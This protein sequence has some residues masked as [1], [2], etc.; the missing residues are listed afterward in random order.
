M[1]IELDIS[2]AHNDFPRDIAM[3]KLIAAAIADPLLIPLAVAA[4]SIL[5]EN[6]IFLRSAEQPSRF[7]HICNSQKVGGQGNALTSLIYVM[8]ENDTLKQVQAQYPGATLKAIHGDIAIFGPSVTIF[9]LKRRC[10][11]I[12]PRQTQSRL[13]PHHQSLE[14]RCPWCHTHRL[15]T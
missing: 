11:R 7:D 12:S 1:I 10:L 15:C 2:N 8:H 5:M 9:G 4:S 6:P 13:R 3:R 14:V